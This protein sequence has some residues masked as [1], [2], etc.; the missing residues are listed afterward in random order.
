MRDADLLMNASGVTSLDAF[1]V[2][3]FELLGI[4]KFQERES[5][6]YIDGRYFIA[7]HDGWSYQVMLSDD[8]YHKDLPFWVGISCKR[9]SDVI[10]R[11]ALDALAWKLVKQHGFK[12]ALIDNFGQT[13]EVRADYLP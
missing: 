3:F 7:A 9:A 1:A 11:S 5:S 12:V 13:S 8:E 10:D 6:H 2:L 4:E